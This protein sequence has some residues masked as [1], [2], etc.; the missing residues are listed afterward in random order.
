LRALRLT[1]GLVRKCYAAEDIAYA[2]AVTRPLHILRHGLRKSFVLPT[3]ASAVGI[4]PEDMCFVD[5]R[6]ENL[7]DSLKA[8]LGLGM[9]APF[10]YAADGTIETFRFGDMIEAFL[11]WAGRDGGISSGNRGLHRLARELKQVDT[12]CRTSITFPRR[13]IKPFTAARRCGHW[14]RRLA[15]A[16]AL[17]PTEPQ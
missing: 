3:L 4:P 6:P 11:L 16:R 5:D 9:L 13:P 2:G 1:D 15:R 7:D 8:G 12:C 14:L 10:D 17:D